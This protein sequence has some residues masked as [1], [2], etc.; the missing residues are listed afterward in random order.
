MLLLASRVLFFQVMGFQKNVHVLTMSTAGTW[1][2]NYI[3]FYCKS[4]KHIDKYSKLWRVR[5]K[6]TWGNYYVNQVVITKPIFSS[7]LLHGRWRMIKPGKITDYSFVV[8]VI[9]FADFHGSD[10]CQAHFQIPPKSVLM[11]RLTASFHMTLNGRFFGRNMKSN[12]KRTPCTHEAMQ[13]VPFTLKK[14]GLTLSLVSVC[15]S[16]MKSRSSLMYCLMHSMAAVVHCRG[17]KAV[18]ALG[19]ITVGS[20]RRCVLQRAVLL[21]LC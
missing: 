18:Y 5:R 12:M 3:P 16:E 9:S 2:G 17:A 14:N 7:P 6:K 1:E 20:K 19:W 8:T 13:V 10:L 11:Q 21:G 15:I 4:R